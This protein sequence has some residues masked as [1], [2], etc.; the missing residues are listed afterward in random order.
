[1]HD[2]LNNYAIYYNYLKIN[3]FNNSNRKLRLK[4][5]S[6]IMPCEYSRRKMD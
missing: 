2:V 1:M 3:D 6:I 5:L 4:I